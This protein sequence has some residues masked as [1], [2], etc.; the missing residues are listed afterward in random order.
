MGRGPV[1][2]TAECPNVANHQWHP[3]GYVAH[4]GWAD[5]ALRVADQKRCPGCKGWEIWVP[6]RPDLRIIDQLFDC[7]WGFCDEEAVGERVDPHTGDWLPVCAEHAEV[8][9]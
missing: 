8:E 9:P 5:M 7:D 3:V 1:T 4:S 2:T 6:K